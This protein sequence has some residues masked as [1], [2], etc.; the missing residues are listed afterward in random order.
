MSVNR[1]LRACFC[2]LLL[3]EPESTRI[4]CQ[5]ILEARCTGLSTALLPCLRSP[6]ILR[7]CVQDLMEYVYICGQ[8]LNPPLLSSCR[9]AFQISQRTNLTPPNP[10]LSRI[11]RRSGATFQTPIRCA[12]FP[13]C[14]RYSAVPP[15]SAG[16][17][18]QLLPFPN[19]SVSICCTRIHSC[20]LRATAMPVFEYP[21][22]CLPCRQMLSP[23]S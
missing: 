5:P 17:Y 11:K 7:V 21:R 19:S 9:N 23:S 1:A 12:S 18:A 22:I 10:A 2:C 15:G 20:A 6:P 4:H 13:V 8:P 14:A 3:Q 16:C